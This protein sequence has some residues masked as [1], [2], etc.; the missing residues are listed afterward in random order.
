MGMSMRPS[1]AEHHALL[2]RYLM[3]F[4]IGYVLFAINAG[5]D[6]R[7]KA[8]TADPA[9]QIEPGTAKL[10]DLASLPPQLRRTV[11]DEIRRLRAGD[12][13]INGDMTSEEA[14]RLES[15]G[16]RAPPRDAAL[17]HF[18]AHAKVPLADVSASDLA[19]YTLAGVTPDGV[20]QDG[21]WSSLK[22]MYRRPD[23][24]LV[25]LH[26][27]AYA[28]EGGGVLGVRELMNATVQ[29]GT[30]RYPA[31]FAIRRATTGQVV[32][33]LRWFTDAKVF[34]LSVAQDVLADGGNAHGKAWLLRLAEAIE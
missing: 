21:P 4:L 10:A 23:G 16:A 2:L 18:N 15:G 5:A 32:S 28:A 29:H 12:G 31:R 33:E 27:W 26:E 11:D 7:K 1:I 25:M 30:A 9:P 3:V 8:D 22:R 13:V 20:G 17:V 19:G 14:H 6:S 24:V 34:T